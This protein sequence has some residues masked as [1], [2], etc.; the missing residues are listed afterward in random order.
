MHI[1]VFDTH[2]YD[3][4]AL[5]TANAS[6]QHRLTFLEPRLTA[7]TASLAAGVAAVCSFV[8]DRVDRRALEMLHQ[9]FLTRGVLEGIA[10]T[11]LE[12]VR[13]FESEGRAQNEVR[14]DRVLG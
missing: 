1:A 9:A 14:A 13:A 5:D 2:T 12:N 7:E 3:R 11:I 6:N 8:N 4:Q 10:G